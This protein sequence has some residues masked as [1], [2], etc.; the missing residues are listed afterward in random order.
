[1]EALKILPALIDSKILSELQKPTVVVGP[2]PIISSDL[3]YFSRFNEGRRSFFKGDYLNSE[4]IFHELDLELSMNIKILTPAKINETICWLYLGRYKEYIQQYENLASNNQIYGAVLWNLIIAFLDDDQLDKAELYLNKWLFSAQYQFKCKGYLL[5]SLVL[6]RNKKLDFALLSLRKAWE[7][8]EFFCTKL[9]K[10]FVKPEIAISLITENA[11]KLLPETEVQEIIAKDEVLVA[12][13][14]LLVSRAPA[15]YPQLAQELSEF[16]YQSGYMTALEKFGDGDINETLKIIDSLL[17]GAGEFDALIWAKSDCLVAKRDW[18]GAIRLIEDQLHDS[19]I[20]G[21]VLWNATCAYFNLGKY[22]LALDTITHCIDSEF[23]TSGSA[24]LIQCFL[25]HLC[26]NNSLRDEAFRH[27]TLVSPQQLIYHISLLKKIGLNI[28]N[29]P[30]P[31]KTSIK[32][33]DDNL[34]LRYNEAREKALILLKNHKRLQAAQEIAKLSTGSITDIPEVEDTTFRPVILPTCIAE[35]YIFKDTF[36]AGVAAFQR[37]AYEEAVQKFDDLYIKTNRSYPVTVNLAASLINTEKYSRAIDVLQNAINIRPHGGSYAVKN[38][39]SAY[40]KSGKPE[41]AYPLFKKLL[42]IST[43][44]YFNFVQMAFVANLL[45]KKEDVASALFN[46]CTEN[47]HEP[48]IRL[49]SAAVYACLDVKDNDRA[50]VLVSYFVEDK[51]LPYVVAGVTR[52]ILAAKECKKYIEMIRQYNIFRKRGDSRAALGYFEGVY[53][54]RE[55]DYGISINSTTVDALFAACVFY[56]QSLYWNNEIDKSH[57]ILSQSVNILNDH[58]P[59]FT[60]YEI[61]KRYFTITSVYVKLGHYFWASELCERGLKADENN[62]G[63][64][65]LCR[66]VEQRIKQIPEKS[67]I[68]IKEMLE[69]PF[70]NAEN[71]DDFIKGLP[72]I[73]QQIHVLREDF[74]PSNK[75]IQKMEDEINFLMTL[76]SIPIIER[77]KIIAVQKESVVAIERDLPLYLPKTFVPAILQVLKGFKKVIDEFQIRSICPEFIL[78]IEPIC[79]YR[80]FEGTLVYKLKNTG[81]ADIIGLK[82][83]ISASPGQKWAP[84]IEERS[85]D[86]VRKDELIWIDWPIHFEFQ[87]DQEIKLK[88]K[89]L[90]KFTGGSLRG[91]IVEQVLEDQETTLNPFIDITVD[92]PVVALRPE[93]NKKLYGRENL[94]RTL[95]NSFSRS[96][97]TRI[98][99]LEG[100]R[101]VGKTSIL[102]FLASRLPEDYL[103][104]YVNLDTSWTNLYGLLSLRINEDIAILTHNEPMDT[105]HITNK[106]EFN[107]F[108]I[109]SLPKTKYQNIVLLLDE[110]HSIIDRIE[111]GIISPEILGDLRYMYMNPQQKISIVL[112]DWFLIDELKRKVPAQIWTDFAREPIS[113]LNELDT[114]E[115]ILQP[116]QGST[117]RYEQDV[118]SKIYYWT[119]GYPWHIQWICSELINFLNIQKRYVVFPQ[120]IDFIAKKLLQEDRLFNEGLCRPERLKETSQKL[121]NNIIV[122][123]IYLKKDLGYSFDIKSIFNSDIS[124]EMNQEILRLQQLDILLEQDNQLRFC[125]PLHA[126]WFNKQRTKGMNIFLEIPNSINN[127]ENSLCFVVPDNPQ[128]IIKE[129][130]EKIREQKIQIRQALGK[131]RQIFKNIEMVDEWKNACAVVNTKDSWGLFIKALRDL[132]VQDMNS[133][134]TEWEDRKLYHE[135]NELLHSIRE[136]RNYVEHEDSTSGKKEEE[137]CCLSDIKK[138]FPTSENDWLILQLKELERVEQILQKT[139]DRIASKN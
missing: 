98:P 88:P 21:G 16:E 86:R 35:I 91:I 70:I 48:S 79:N 9:I 58:S 27:A 100:V 121:I 122:K 72:R 85:Y 8:D 96:G 12:L 107:R 68:S 113:F 104:I 99:F 92:Y 127:P 126:L 24:W 129:K 117:V 14:S 39:I 62:A 38:L 82:I 60:A 11:S 109:K 135:L 41:D 46:A 42:E 124:S 97:Q 18:E 25:A 133:R 47:I 103:P 3:E 84:I 54:A 36:L 123:L 76:D 33:D 49:Q 44:E 87:Q 74:L 130:C 139:L 102:Y 132:F 120:D 78:N 19:N 61:S 73:M 23:R 115:A 65:K 45:G 80:E 138:K 20:P 89:M 95:R 81:P 112:A 108:L 17:K 66:E 71:T 6:Y 56:G 134:L 13:Q 26:S 15:K 90:L 40:M 116:A 93:E 57:E 51:P 2:G 137:K 69:F 83:F 22:P 29:L 128:A 118:V 10:R 37:K 105:T 55:E 114:R 67:R 136:R 75:V 125:S 31:I 63:L 7:I 111:K 1:M 64:K 4:K 28:D 94:L 101:K 32:I 30:V 106:E 52:P 53:S 50:F 5:L 77:K 43:K 110:F 34:V 59:K 119:N 131:N